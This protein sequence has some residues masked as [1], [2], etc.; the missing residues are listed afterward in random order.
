[1]SHLAHIV[2]LKQNLIAEGVTNPET[3]IAIA[4]TAYVKALIT[5]NTSNKLDEEQ[6]IEFNRYV[7]SYWN[8]TTPVNGLI[9]MKTIG[10]FFRN[11]DNFLQH[12]F[13][14]CVLKIQIVPYVENP[15]DLEYTELETYKSLVQQLVDEANYKLPQ[16]ME[17]DQIV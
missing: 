16:F 4:R 12:T 10:D 2:K 7:L 9:V 15:A 17:T 11:L 5:V 1:M 14:D 8:E 3:Q 13:T 6:C